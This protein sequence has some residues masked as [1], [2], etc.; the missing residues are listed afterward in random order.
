MKKSQQF[1]IV[2]LEPY[3]VAYWTT[4]FLYRGPPVYVEEILE[5]G[6]NT[7]GLLCWEI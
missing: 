4:D 2:M 6:R 3:D 7:P 5:N 1:I